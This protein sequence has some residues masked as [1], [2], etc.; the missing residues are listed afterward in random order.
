MKKI[1]IVDDNPTNRE[2]LKGLLKDIAQTMD[3]V[4]GLDAQTKFE[5]AIIGDRSPF[6]L[7]LLDL[8]MPNLNGIEFLKNIRDLEKRHQLP[9]T[10]VIVITSHKSGYFESILE[11]CNDFLMK[12]IVRDKLME[13]VHSY[14]K[15]PSSN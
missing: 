5:Q 15:N 2:L 9:Q 7:V 8:E 10:P 13:T 6:D 3:G 12:P 1:L 4:D 14:L 11:G